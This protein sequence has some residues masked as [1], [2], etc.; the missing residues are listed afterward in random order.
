MI[1][2]STDVSNLL[3]I[4]PSWENRHKPENIFAKLFF[5]PTVCET[6]AKRAKPKKPKTKKKTKWTN[7][8]RTNDQ[9][10]KKKRG[11][12]REGGEGRKRKG[13]R[14]KEGKEGKGGEGRERGK[15]GKRGEGKGREG[16]RR[17]EG[18]EEGKGTM[19]N[20][21]GI[22]LSMNL[23]TTRQTSFERKK[24]LVVP[25]IKSMVRT[26]SMNQ[27]NTDYRQC[28]I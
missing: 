17:G 26:S 25:W 2:G 9:G 24:Q 7:K 16:R 6:T 15:G 18:A 21:V 22:H 5:F 19:S 12:G 10:G 1:Y 28:Q 14:E 23:A 27:F 20:L 13:R 11:K 4:P 8:E 3:P